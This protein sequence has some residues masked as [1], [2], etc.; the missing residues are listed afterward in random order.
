MPGVICRDAAAEI[1]L[2][3]DRVKCINAVANEAQRRLAEARDTIH[4]ARVM[5]VGARIA[6]DEAFEAL[7]DWLVQVVF[8][9]ASG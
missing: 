6:Y 5:A 4:K 8:N 7:E 1:E 9:D 2:L 3:R